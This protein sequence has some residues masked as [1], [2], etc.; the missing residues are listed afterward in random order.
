MHLTEAGRTFLTEARSILAQ[1]QRAIQLAQAAS[2]GEAGHL[3]IAYS[4]E[5]IE[6]ILVSAAKSDRKATTNDTPAE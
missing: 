4:I 3:D 5:G 1:S 2:R 6:P